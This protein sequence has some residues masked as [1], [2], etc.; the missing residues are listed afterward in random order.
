MKTGQRPETTW[1]E[2]RLAREDYD[3]VIRLEP[4]HAVAHYS[5]GACLA[6]LGDLAG[7]VADFDRATALEPG[8]AVPYYNRGCTYGE[9]GDVR[10]ALEDFD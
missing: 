8:D 6:K 1:G 7:A 10:R 4:D 9:M 5:Q 3:A 2:H